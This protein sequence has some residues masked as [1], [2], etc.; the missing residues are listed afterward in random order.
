MVQRVP[1]ARRNVLAD[2]RRLAVSILGVGAALMLVLLLRGLW[3]GMLAQTSVYPDRVDADLIVGEAGARTLFE[4]S[5]LASGTVDEVRGLRGVDAADGIV[6]R[7]VM[8]ELDGDKIPLSLVGARPGGLGGPWR[9]SEGRPPSADTDAVLDRSLAG[10]Y[11]LAVGDTLVVLDRLVRI[12]GLSEGSR[13]LMGGG[14]L[15]MTD[16]GARELLQTPGV[17]SFVLVETATPDQVAAVLEEQLGV[18]ALTTAEAAA[19]GRQ[20]IAGIMGGPVNLMIVIAFVAGTMIVALTT[21]S[22]VVERVREYG[23]AKAMGATAGRLF[24]TILGQTLVLTALGAAASAPLYLAASR[25]ITAVR[26]QF[27]FQVD[28]AAVAVL[29]ASAAA[30]ALFA[31]IMPARRVSRLDPATVYRG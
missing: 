7:W 2:R 11:G 1:I 4:S 17:T 31:A 12:S 21:Y 24:V 3:A 5:V 15:F 26:P 8:L 13:S 30:M 22:S 27:G 20:L 16:V 28:P 29:A 10:Q 25:L 14:L 23:I 18:D 6:L 9:L 19:N